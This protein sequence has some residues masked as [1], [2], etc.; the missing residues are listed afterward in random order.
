MNDF[1]RLCNLFID[2]Q[3]KKIQEVKFKITKGDL[4]NHVIVVTI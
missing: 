4:C 1:L 3:T 2:W